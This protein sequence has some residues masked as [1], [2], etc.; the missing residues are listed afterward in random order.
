MVEPTTKPG[1]VARIKALADNDPRWEEVLMKLA[2]LVDRSIESRD[3]QRGTDE[4]RADHDRKDTAGFAEIRVEIA[5]LKAGVGSV[6]SMV[7]TEQKKNSYTL[8]QVVGGFLALCGALG[9]LIVF[10]VWAIGHAANGKP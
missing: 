4:W 1:E 9:G 6:T 8:T 5:T 3:W 7:S 2:V 10:I